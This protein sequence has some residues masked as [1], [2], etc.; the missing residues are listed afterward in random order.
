MAIA[1]PSY[2]TTTAALVTHVGSYTDAQRTA[3]AS[4]RDSAIATQ[5]SDTTAVHGVADYAGL[6]YTL[7]W[8][9]TSNYVPA[10]LRTVTERPRVFIGP[11]DPATIGSITLASYDVWWEV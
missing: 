4:A 1:Q 2:P 6:C 8:D 9:G 11:T 5:G 3:E 7:K 10:S